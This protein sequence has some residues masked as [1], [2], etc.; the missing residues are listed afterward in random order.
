MEPVEGFIERGRGR[1]VSSAVVIEVVLPF[2]QK[3]RTKPP[4]GLGHKHIHKNNQNEEESEQKERTPP[5]GNQKEIGKLNHDRYGCQSNRIHCAEDE[6]TTIKAEGE[7]GHP[8]GT[9][10][11]PF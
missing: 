4:F 5:A 3:Q 6:R 8:H 7:D 2:C 11:L 9:S 10:N 1:I